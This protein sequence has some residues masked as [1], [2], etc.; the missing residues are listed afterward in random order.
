MRLLII[1]GLS[2]CATSARL[3]ETRKV[4][5][6]ETQHGVPVADPYRWLE[7]DTPEVASWVAAQNDATRDWLDSV[8][9]R[10]KIR[11]RLVQLWDYERIASPVVRGPRVF[12][13]H[14][15]GTLNQLRLV[16]RDGA[17]VRTLFDPAAEDASG[18]TAIGDHSPDGA[19]RRVA[20]TLSS[21]GSD[22]V[23][24][25]VVNVETGALEPDRLEWVK[26]TG[27]AWAPDDSG[28]FYS[29]YDAPPPGEALTA[30]NEFQKVYFHRLG[31]TQARD[32]LVYERKDQPEWSFGGD[33]THDGRWQVLVVY[34]GADRKNG[35]LVREYGSTGP[36]RELIG[37]DFAAS[38]EPVAS[39]GNTLY[40]RT[41]SEAPLGRIAALPF[42]GSA[43][44]RTIVPESSASLDTATQAGNLLVVTVLEDASSAVRLYGLD[45]S[46]KGSVP[47]PGLGTVFGLGGRPSDPSIAFVFSGFLDP[48]KLI[49]HDTSTGISTTLASAEVPG[50][51]PD[52]YRV[53]R[54]LTTSRDGTRVPMFFVLR[55]GARPDGEL[56]VYLYGYGGFNISLTPWFSPGIAAF[57]ELGGA[58]AVPNLRGGGEFGEAW[59]RAGMLHNKQNVFDDFIGA[60]EW[61]IREGWTRPGRLAIAGGSNGGLLVGAALVQRPELF[62][63]VLPVVGVLDMLRFHKFTIK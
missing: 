22:W 29:R 7:S 3:P 19:G 21:G 44:P 1:L 38:W 48:G 54:V 40:V 11:E 39:D 10:P 61:L 28:F 24:V 27:L 2:A 8:E 57:L 55:R 62:G 60:A 37:M 31:E 63:A 36:F 25:R 18:T 26:F 59:H 45:G 47:L 9:A 20:F 35:V 53:E 16:V 56:P 41:D 49:R 34:R 46:P 6:V 14:N 4:D 50:F 42:D 15:P 51:Q 30:K 12:H 13:L 32:T 23:T 17:G 33:V 52:R 43:P 58:Y 5:V